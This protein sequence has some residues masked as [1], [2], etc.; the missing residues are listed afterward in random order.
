MF[1]NLAVT[2]QSIYLSFSGITARLEPLVLLGLRLLAARV[3][4]KS[5]LAKVETVEV[6][7][8][9]LP[10]PEIQN[11][12]YFLFGNLYFPNMPEWFTDLA[13]IGAT[14]GELSLSLLLAFGFI[15]RFGALGLLVM[16]AVIQI[17]V[18]PAEWWAV[19]AWWAAALA[20]VLVRGP[21]FISIDQFI[22]LNQK[23]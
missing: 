11:G 8:F 14:I 16:T 2:G 12:T 10:T 5:G 19:H 6:L 1:N 7:G 18:F 21:G 22:G 3:F 9:R 15:A 23:N 20:V 17:F 4:W 13:A